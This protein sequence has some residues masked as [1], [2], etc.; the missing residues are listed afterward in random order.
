MPIAITLKLALV[1]FVVG[2]CTG[3]GWAIAHAIVARLNK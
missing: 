2:L 1:W 3:L